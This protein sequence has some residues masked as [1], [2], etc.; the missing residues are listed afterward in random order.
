MLA[1]RPRYD[2]TVISSGL[3][4]HSKDY[5]NLPERYMKRKMSKVEYKS[6]EG[7][8]YLEKLYIAPIRRHTM[9]RPWTDKYWQE[10]PPFRHPYGVPSVDDEPWN[11]AEVKE[12]PVVYPIKDDDWMW[13]RG[14]RVEVLVGPDKGKQ[15]Y[16]NMIVQERNWVTVEGLNCEYKVM[17]DGQD[18]PGMMYKEEQPLLVTTDVKLVDPSDEKAARVDWRYTEDGERVRVSTRSG[19]ILPLPAQMEETQD[20]KTKAG[21]SLNKEKDTPPNMVEEITYEPRLATFEMDIVD[22]MGIKEDRRAARTWWY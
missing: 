10:N 1:R 15:G 22:R 18:F 12:P 9:D 3:A 8:Q 7:V 5:A 2:P 14:D 21:Y 4:K 11:A 20:Y 17:G 6:P 19:T 13:F 16:I